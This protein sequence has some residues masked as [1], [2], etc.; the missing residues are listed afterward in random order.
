[1]ATDEKTMT[2][3][4]RKLEELV[5]NADSKGLTK[6]YMGLICLT[7]SNFVSMPLED[8]KKLTN[9]FGR[10][11]GCLGD[12]GVQIAALLVE[13]NNGFVKEIRRG[14]ND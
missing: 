12:E 13:M 4:L 8:R 9:Q 2:E 7:M 5:V 14:T 11:L 10:I 3:F 6:S 1:M